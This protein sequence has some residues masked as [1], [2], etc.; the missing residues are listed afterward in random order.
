LNIIIKIKI[1]KKCEVYISKSNVILKN[2]KIEFINLIKENFTHDEVEK[3]L[4]KCWN[5]ADSYREQLERINSGYSNYD[6]PTKLNKKQWIK[7]NLK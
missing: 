6:K 3:L 5:A 4:N 7:K 2:N 1:I